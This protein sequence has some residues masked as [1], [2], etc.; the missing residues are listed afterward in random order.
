MVNVGLSVSA[1]VPSSVAAVL[2]F[3]AP[4]LN[5]PAATLIDFTIVL[6]SLRPLVALKVDVYWV[7]LTLVS[8]PRVP[9]ATV[10]SANSKVLEASLSVKVRVA[11]SLSALLLVIATQGFCVS[12]A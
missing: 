2:R 12:N 1:L 4:S 8:A 11:A 7:L 6:P 9:P 10:I 3:P 5:V